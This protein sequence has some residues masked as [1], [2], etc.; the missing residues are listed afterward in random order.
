VVSEFAGDGDERR[1]IDTIMSKL[2]NL[3]Q[4]LQIW[5][6]L[7]V[8]LRKT[9]AGASFEEGAVPTTD[10][11]RGSGSIKQLSNGVFAIARNQQHDNEYLRNTSSVH[12]LKCRFTG[13]TGAAGW[14][15]FHGESGRMI[16]VDDPEEYLAMQ[17][18]ADEQALVA[19]AVAAGQA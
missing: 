17:N 14:L 19:Q 2:K 8:H 13:R 12:S 9:S 18:S 1:Q 7:V 10:D 16:P 4:E 11:L 6:G 3:T 15:H 5:I